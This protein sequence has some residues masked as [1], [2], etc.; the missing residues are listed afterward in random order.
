M[1]FA[2][3]LK[4][5]TSFQYCRNIS[6]DLYSFIVEFITR[7]CLWNGTWVQADYQDCEIT[8]A[9]VDLVY[10]FVGYIISLVALA[11]AIFVFTFFKY[12]FFI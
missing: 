10:Y 9:E 3:K 12:V 11:I 4:L 2:Y 7:D 6:T 8:P 1:K 5:I